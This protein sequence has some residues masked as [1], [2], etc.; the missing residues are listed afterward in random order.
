MKRILTYI[1][2]LLV[3]TLSV[4]TILSM[5]FCLCLLQSFNIQKLSSNMCC[6]AA[7]TG[8]NENANILSLNHIESE[9]SCCSTTALEVV[10]DNFTPNS[11]Q[12]IQSPTESTYMPGWFVVNY[13]INLIASDTTTESN[14]NFPIY[15]SFLKTLDFLSLI[16]VY[17]L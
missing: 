9:N 15:G 3:L 6:M 12:S 10:T 17:R 5:H 16:C 13:L 2:L 1:L 7:E 4:H 14:F 8:E 11:S